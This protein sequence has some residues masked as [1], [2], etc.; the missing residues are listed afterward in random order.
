MTAGAAGAD[1]ADGDAGAVGASDRAGAG[2]TDRADVIVVGAGIAGLVAAEAVYRAGRSVL[3][4]EARDRV[5]GRMRSV[6]DA[7]GAIELGAT[8][9]WANESAVIALVDRLGVDT[10]DQFSSGD[11]LFEPGRRRMSGVPGVGDARRFTAGAG[12]LAGRLAARLPPG[13]VRLGSPVVALEVDDDEVRVRTAHGEHRARHAVVALPPP[14]VAERIAITPQP[15]AALAEKVVRTQVW[16][17]EM[18]KAVA[19]YPEAFWRDEGLSGL[20]MSHQGPF[21]EIHDHSGP[22][23][24]PSAVFGF[25]PSASFVGVDEIAIAEAFTAQLVRLFGGRAARPSRVDVVDWSRESWTTPARP[26]PE[27]STAGYGDPVFAV[28]VGGRLHW[29]STETAT[30]FAGHVEGAIRSGLRAADA[31]VGALAGA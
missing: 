25:A 16:M 20:V 30:R 21:R 24:S 27:R 9:F 18:T 28:P 13:S 15:P 17:G 26:H 7:N 4:I 22:H 19:V 14:L 11:A 3:V 6:G 2:R 23:G 1:G 5:G 8:W 12:D 31:V 10:F 29:A